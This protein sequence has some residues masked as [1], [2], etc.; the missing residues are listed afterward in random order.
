MGKDNGNQQ[1]PVPRISSLCVRF[2]VLRQK[3][4]KR[5]DRGDNE[6]DALFSLLNQMHARTFL[7]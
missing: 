2:P 3:D 1:V 7:V 6:V 5:D 4:W